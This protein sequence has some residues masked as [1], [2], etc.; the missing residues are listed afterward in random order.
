MKQLPNRKQLEAV[1]QDRVWDFGNSILYN[2]CKNNFEHL[3]DEHI[4][5]KVLFIGRIYAA[6]VERRK[7]KSEDINDNFYTEKVIPAFADPKFD[8]KLSKLKSLINVEIENIGTILQTH[9]YLVSKLYE[10]TELNKRSFSSK[11]L[12]FHLPDL[13]YI[14]DSRVVTALRQFISK[15]PKDL[16]H[17]LKTDNID[18][19]YAKFYCKC[20]ALK[21][22]IQTK[23]KIDLTTRQLDNLLVEVANKLNIEKQKRTQ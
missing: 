8:E 13:F 6:A 10:I 21:K 22:E 17:I 7:N 15:D 14:Y 16:K 12:H 5:T 11:Y 19:E 3:E 1:Q 4:L 2:L 18:L 23:F 9:H 20:F